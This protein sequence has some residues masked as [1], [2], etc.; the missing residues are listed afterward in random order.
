MGPDAGIRESTGGIGLDLHL[1]DDRLELRQDFFGFGEES[2]PRWRVVLSYEFLRKLW[3]LG[4]VDGILNDD[5][6]DY[7][8]GLELRFN[9]TDLKSILP[10]APTNSLSP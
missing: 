4:G 9:D 1:L 10:F 5:R 3:L 7:F 6:R 2:T 8:F